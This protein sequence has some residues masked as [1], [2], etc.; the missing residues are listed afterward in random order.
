MGNFGFKIMQPC[1]PGRRN[2]LFFVPSQLNCFKLALPIPSTKVETKIPKPTLE[3]SL[4]KGWG[5]DQIN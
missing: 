5:Q 3:A 1:F 4:L 2:L